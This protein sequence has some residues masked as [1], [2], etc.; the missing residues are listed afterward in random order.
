MPGQ[1]R[2]SYRGEIQV[3]KS[4]VKSG[5]TVRDPRHLMLHGKWGKTKLCELRKPKVEPQN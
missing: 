4:H 1:P 5:F 3:I 2:W